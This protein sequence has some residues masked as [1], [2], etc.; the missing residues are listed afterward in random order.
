[1]PEPRE[2]EVSA[3]LLPGA[4]SPASIDGGS[5]AVV[6]SLVAAFWPADVS[7]ELTSAGV[8]AATVGLV[9]DE[10]TASVVG[11]TTPFCA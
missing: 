2:G 7:D 9:R 6:G 5:L 1:M 3:A 11:A 4:G 8:S 10:G